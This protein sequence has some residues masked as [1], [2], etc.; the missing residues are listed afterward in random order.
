MS[1]LTELL[2]RLAARGIDHRP[3][4][5]VPCCQEKLPSFQHSYEP[6]RNMFGNDLSWILVLNLKLCFNTVWTCRIDILSS[7]ETCKVNN[8]ALCR[9]MCSWIDYQR[10]VN[11]LVEQAGMPQMLILLYFCRMLKARNLSRSGRW[12]AVESHQQV[13]LILKLF[14]YRAMY[15]TSQTMLP[16]QLRIWSWHDVLCITVECHLHCESN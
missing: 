6:I 5:I 4:S 12:G 11:S 14:R 15:Q 13:S 10:K 16:V 7:P 3:L 9:W 1:R 8:A 2:E